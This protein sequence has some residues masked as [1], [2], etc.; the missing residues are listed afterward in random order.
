MEGTAPIRRLGLKTQSRDTHPKAEAA[1][2]ALIRR[3]S[4]VD[5]LASV[6]SL[7][8]TVAQLAFDGICRSHPG[9][10][11]EEVLRLFVSIHYGQTIADRLNSELA[12]RRQ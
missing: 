1:Q 11:R 6:W 7:T 8:Q 3:A 9:A 4:H 12:R 5:R 2:I 10:S